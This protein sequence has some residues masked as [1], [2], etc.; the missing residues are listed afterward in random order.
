M[1]ICAAIK[2]SSKTSKEEFYVCGVRHGDCYTTL[3]HVCYNEPHTLTEGFMTH[4]GIFVDRAGAYA[5]ARICGQVAPT[6][7]IR[8]T[9]NEEH[10]L[11]SEDLW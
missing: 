2:V 3:R 1:I 5:H 4:E 8:K 11:Y 10:K 7:I 9:E 6:T